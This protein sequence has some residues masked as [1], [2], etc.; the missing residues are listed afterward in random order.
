MKHL[1]KTL[2]AT[3]ITLS[4]FADSTPSIDPVISD[5]NPSARWG[6]K[7]KDNW[8]ITGEAVWFKPIVSQITKSAVTGP[9]IKK[10]YF[11]NEFQIGGRV[12]LGYNTGYDGWD[13]VFTY[14]RLNYSHSN[15][16]LNQLSNQNYIGTAEW[17]YLFNQGALDLGRMFSVSK[18]L[19]LRP[20]TGIRGTWLQETTATTYSN[21][22]QPIYDKLSLKDVMIGLKVG[23]DSTWMFSKEFSVYS[24]LA[25]ASLVD[26]DQSSFITTLSTANPESSSTNHGSHIVNAIDFALGLR[27]DRNFLN[28]RFHLGINIGYEQHAFINVNTIPSLEIQGIGQFEYN[29]SADFNLQGLAFGAR[30]DF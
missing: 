26:N 5:P 4:A 29:T 19:K 21:N 15:P 11:Q 2:L 8:F 1:I 16:F 24:N 17:G 23:V 6:T 10:T 18:H 22:N 25:F 7:S 30:F 3:S 27:W 12:A 28:D 9:S 14:T 13:T 20:Y